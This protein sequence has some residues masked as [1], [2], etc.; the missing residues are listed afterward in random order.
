MKLKI[1]IF[2]ILITL[3]SCSKSKKT[4]ELNYNLKIDTT[5][6]SIIKYDPTNN[7]CK[8]VFKTGTNS[9]LN[10]EDLDK[11]EFTIDKIIKKQNQIQ[12]EWFKES[13]KLYPKENY[14]KE[15]FIL[16]KTKYIRRYLVI[17]NPQGEKEVYVALVCDEIAKTFDFRKTLKQG[18]GGGACLFSFKLN[19][20]TNKY[21]DVLVNSEA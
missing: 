20:E 13:L 2:F 9:Y 8:I 21:Y 7:D 19:F 6:V 11:I 18:H 3:N 1:V 4:S 16:K 17:K 14:K 12:I 10:N 15:D 5:R